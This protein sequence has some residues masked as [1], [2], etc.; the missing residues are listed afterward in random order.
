[1][2]SDADPRMGEPPVGAPLLA[3]STT[4]H[5]RVFGSFDAK[6]TSRE[7]RSTVDT[8]LTGWQHGAPRLATLLLLVSVHSSGTAHGQSQRPDAPESAPVESDAPVQLP[9][10][11]GVP[12]KTDTDPTLLRM[13]FTFF[14]EFLSLRTADTWKSTFNVRPALPLTENFSLIST[15]PVVGTNSSSDDNV[16]I[17]DIDLRA[18][19]LVFKTNEVGLLANLETNLPTAGG[20]A[21]G[22]G[23]LTLAPMVTIGFFLRENLILAPSYKHEYG[24]WVMSERQRFQKGTLELYLVWR[25][26][27]AAWVTVDP[28]LLVDYERDGQ[29]YGV[30]KLQLG[31]AIGAIGDT[32]QSIYVQPTTS[33]GQFRTFNSGA[34]TGFKSVF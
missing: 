21:L 6:R 10:P 16:G 25:P 30:F 31:C 1:V 2:V 26:T 24:I 8:T 28:Q 3:S 29:V 32:L 17:G 7:D 14:N 11:K 4:R 13:S 12:D 20:D 23:N 27:A 15:L 18:K 9:T 5:A 34:E 33:V 22:I 19:W